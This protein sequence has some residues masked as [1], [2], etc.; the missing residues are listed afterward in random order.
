MINSFYLAPQFSEP[1][2]ETSDFNA[3]QHQHMESDEVFLDKLVIM[4]LVNT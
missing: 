2:E 1:A 3:H 4:Q